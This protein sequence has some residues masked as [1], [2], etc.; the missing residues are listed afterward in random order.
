MISLS[1]F[2][3]DQIKQK[4]ISKQKITYIQ[5]LCYNLELDAYL[6]KYLDVAEF[7]A[8]IT[9]ERLL[10]RI[11]PLSTWEVTYFFFEN[12]VQHFVKRAINDLNLSQEYM[13]NYNLVKDGPRGPSSLRRL[14]PLLNF[15]HCSKMILL[16]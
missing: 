10:A 3:G 8:D 5:R 14:F 7:L 11:D 4:K 15:L 13:R 9:V 16:R 6:K 1:A 2:V 12:K